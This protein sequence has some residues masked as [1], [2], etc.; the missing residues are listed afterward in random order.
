MSSEQPKKKRSQSKSTRKSPRISSKKSKS[1]KPKTIRNYTNFSLSEGRIRKLMPKVRK[2]EDAV[3]KLKKM[4]DD[5]I[6]DLWMRL[7]EYFPDKK[8]FTYNNVRWV[9]NVLTDARRNCP[10]LT[11]NGA[12]TL[13]AG[14]FDAGWEWEYEGA[15]ASEDETEDGS[16]GLGGRRYYSSSSSSSSSSSGSSD[17]EDGSTIKCVI[18]PN[19]P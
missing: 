2:S 4:T 16:M 6:A 19:R 7:H 18:R 1:G 15:G 13:A 9:L 8:T 17:E 14:E 11:G 5:Y 3:K 10:T 12:D